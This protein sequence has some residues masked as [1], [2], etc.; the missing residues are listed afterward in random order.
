MARA[1]MPPNTHTKKTTFGRVMIK[2]EAGRKEA[3]LIKEKQKNKNY[4][5]RNVQYMG[6]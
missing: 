2:R 1:Y 5:V 4:G 6:S 3:S